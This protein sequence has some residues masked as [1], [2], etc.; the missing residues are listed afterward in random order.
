MQHEIWKLLEIKEEIYKNIS[1]PP[2]PCSEEEIKVAESALGLTF[3]EGYRK[4][5]RIYGGGFVG[6]FDIYGLRARRLNFI[7]DDTLREPWSVVYQTNS[8]RAEEWPNSQD[9]YIVSNDGAGNPFGVDPKGHVWLS[10]HNTC[11]LI[12]A[13]YSFEDFLYFLHT[14]TLWQPSYL[15]KPILWPEEWFKKHRPELSS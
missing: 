2:E 7:S 1:S 8:F 12:K 5:L 11:E 14:N 13:A 3:H 6:A 4:Y 15:E 9:W 10:D